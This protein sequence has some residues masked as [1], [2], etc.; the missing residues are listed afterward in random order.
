MDIGRVLGSL[1]ASPFTSEAGLGHCEYDEICT[2]L[3]QEVSVDQRIVESVLPSFVL[4]E[5][6]DFLAAPDPYRAADVYPW[7]FNRGLS[8]LRRPLIA[9]GCSSGVELV[10]RRTAHGASEVA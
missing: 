1:S 7:R 6:A 5:R 4:V 8:Y 10:C 2:Y 9:R 3:A